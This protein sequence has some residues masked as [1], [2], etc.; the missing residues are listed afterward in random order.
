MHNQLTSIGLC[1]VKYSFSL[2]NVFP[3]SRSKEI[4]QVQIFGKDE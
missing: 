4:V 2:N 1:V 3:V